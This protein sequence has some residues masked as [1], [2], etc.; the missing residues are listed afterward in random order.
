MRSLL[1]TTRIFLPRV[2]EKSEAD[3]IARVLF[4]SQSARNG[5]LFQWRFVL[6]VMTLEL[7]LVPLPLYARNR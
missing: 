5:E 3:K 2:R 6:T 1:L 4:A 7:G